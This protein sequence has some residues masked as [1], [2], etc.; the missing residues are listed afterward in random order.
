MKENV[1]GCIRS[2]SPLCRIVEARVASHLLDQEADCSLLTAPRPCRRCTGLSPRRGESNCEGGGGG[3]KQCSAPLATAHWYKYIAKLLLSANH[4]NCN[5]MHCVCGNQG[6]LLLRFLIQSPKLASLKPY[7]WMWE[8]RQQLF[9]EVEQVR[10]EKAAAAGLGS[11]RS[12]SCLLLP[13]RPVHWHVSR[14][15]H[16][17]SSFHHSLYLY[18]YFSDRGNIFIRFISLITGLYEYF[19]GKGTVFERTRK[20]FWRTG[21]IF[22]WY[23]INIHINQKLSIKQKCHK[24]VCK[25][26]V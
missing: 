1:K 3:G 26:Q 16:T 7:K 15:Q 18:K 12:R 23:Q 24:T 9:G 5:L 2:G 22:P 8:S 14:S 6:V 13:G 10:A 21:N 20:Y 11:A 17:L 4:V 25:L 19:F